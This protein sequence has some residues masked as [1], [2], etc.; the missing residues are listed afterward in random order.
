MHSTEMSNYRLNPLFL[1]TGMV[2]PA[3]QCV[4]DRARCDV[5]HGVS[6]SHRGPEV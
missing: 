3:V 5:R 2:G 1:D 6:F 4:K